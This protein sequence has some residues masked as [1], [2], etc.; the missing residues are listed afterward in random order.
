LGSVLKNQIRMQGG[1]KANRATVLGNSI[2]MVM[3]CNSQDGEA[4][5]NKQEMDKFSVH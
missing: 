4:K 5:T 3:K 1:M 2:R